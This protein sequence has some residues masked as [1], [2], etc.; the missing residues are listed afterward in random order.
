MQSPASHCTVPSATP[1]E[2]G[3]LVSE[4]S[5]SPQHVKLRPRHGTSSKQA[6][7]PT[8]KSSQVST[9]ITRRYGCVHLQPTFPPGSPNPQIN[10]PFRDAPNP[11]DS[12]Y[13]APRPRRQ[14]HRPNQ[15]TSLR[16]PP[17][18]PA[19]VA[20]LSA[21]IPHDAHPVGR[22]VQDRPLKRLP[23]LGFLCH[24]S[25]HRP[26]ALLPSASP[27]LHPLKQTFH[28]LTSIS[29]RSASS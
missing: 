17:P 27:I 16:P 3:T 22:L 29:Q 12:V 20:D 10:P 28:L 25:H 7:T 2:W 6:Q 15:T 14:R 19:P 18:K 21:P 5:G 26:Y 1:A 9:A 13:P 24:L 11:S 8:T 23:R 4:I